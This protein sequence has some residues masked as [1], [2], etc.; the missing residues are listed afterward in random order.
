LK[1]V[2]MSSNDDRFAVTRDFTATGGFVDQVRAV[3]PA[4]V[5]CNRPSG[6]VDLEGNPSHAICAGE[7][8]EAKRAAKIKRI[9]A[10]GGRIAPDAGNRDL[11]VVMR[12]VEKHSQGPR[13]EIEKSPA[14]RRTETMR[15][16][17]RND[18]PG[19]RAPELI[20]R[21]TERQTYDLSDV[22][23]DPYGRDDSEV[24][25]RARRAVELG[26]YP[27]ASRD[28][29]RVQDHIDR[30]LRRQNS[31]DWQCGQLARRIL[32][33]GS[34]QYQ[35][36]FAKAMI[37][38]LS[39]MPTASGLSTEEQKLLTRALA[40]SVGSTGG[41]ALPFQLDGTITPTSSSQSNPFRAICRQEVTTSNT[42]GQATSGAMTASYG[43]EASVST[44][45]S[46]TLAQVPLTMQRAQAFT[47]VS[48]ELDQ[49][50]E[51]ILDRLGT[52]IQEAKDD[53]EAV[54][55]TT[56]TGTLEPTGVITA[57]T[58]SSLA[59]AL[60]SLY[61]IETDLPPRWRKRA[62]WLG[63]RARYQDIRKFVLPESA[64]PVWEHVPGGATEIFGYPA[65]ENSAMT[66]ATSSG[67]KVLAFGDPNAYVIVDRIG[68]DVEAT[69]YHTQQTI[70]GAGS[71]LPTGQKGILAL[72]RNNANLLA[73]GAFRILT[74][75]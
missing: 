29:E 19:P 70:F 37:G 15:H 47:P 11:A 67:S 56:G 40:A 35:R 34:P 26:Y 24:I 20:S 21:M 3:S 55:F 36:A 13:A 41:F 75:P 30:L 9:K 57:G 60:A 54:K 52:L 7:S 28:Q 66:T 25:N 5:V 63:N 58:A 74:I 49:D 32:I 27:V 62:V 33:T 16:I 53:L 59:F 45:N 1:V 44:D 68:L 17:H 46:P 51:A 2:Q 14:E 61:T 23:V 4:C 18:P 22:R 72:W 69:S 73:A 6:Y 39:G 12:E 48:Y 64:A 10:R 71:S 8:S 50:W 42:W 65:Y 43:A 31:R 38:A